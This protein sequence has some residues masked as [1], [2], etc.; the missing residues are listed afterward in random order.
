MIEHSDGDD[1]LYDKSIIYYAAIRGDASKIAEWTEDA[2][3]SDLD[4]EIM[5]GAVIAGHPDVVSAL[6]E[7]GASPDWQDAT[8]MTPLLAAASCKRHEIMTL[9]IQ[10]GADL[11]KPN[12]DGLDPM[13]QAITLRDGKAVKL[14]LDAGFDLHQSELENGYTPMDVALMAEDEQVIDRLSEHLR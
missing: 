9:L 6:L 10:A 5:S 14:L 2:D 12:E 8:G 11:Q 13:L 1:R 7:S 3:W 4:P